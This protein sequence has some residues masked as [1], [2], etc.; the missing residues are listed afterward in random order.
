MLLVSMSL[1]LASEERIHPA[2]K[3]LTQSL[4]NGS[5]GNSCLCDKIIIPEPQGSGAEQAA[6]S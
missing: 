4:C 6:T 3:G 2:Q 1:T 5:N